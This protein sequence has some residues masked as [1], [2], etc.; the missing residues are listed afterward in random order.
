MTTEYGVLGPLVAVRDGVP[1]E[2][3][4][5]RQ[6]AVLARLL[7]AGGRALPLDT[8]VDEVWETVPDTAV[9]TAQKYVSQL[10]SVL[11]T[12]MVRT[13]GRGYAVDLDDATLDADRFERLLADGEAEAAL[14][15]WRGEPLDGLPDLP[16]VT[17]ERTRLTELRAGA[18]EL[19]LQHLLDAGRHEL[20][21]PE[22]AQ[23]F[24]RQ[25]A[26][27]R[28]CALLMLAL[29]R[30]GRQ[31]E[32]LETF[33]CHR[34]RLADELG[35]EPGADLAALEVSILHQDAG[36]DPPTRG[37]APA[38]GN[39]PRPVSSFV[40]RERDV[41]RVIAGLGGHRVVTLTGPGGVGKTRLA[42][43][44]GARVAADHPAG[45][46]FVD[47]GA[48]ADPGLI[49][50]SL[51]GA[52]G[53]ADQPDQ[54][55]EETV[56]AAL[57]HREPL[58]LLLDNCEHLADRC[59]ALA[60]R[61]ARGCPGV[62][63][64]ATSR[65]PLG[66]DGECVLPVAPL[67]DGDARRLFADRARLA[68]T[69]EAETTAAA[70]AEV[71]RAV[72]G[73][74]LAL[75]LAAGQMR[76]LGPEALTA[77]LDERLTFESSRFDAPARQRTLQDMVAWSWALLPPAT[78]RFFA[79]LGVFAATF[80]LDAAA[81]V[82]GEGSPRRHLARLVEHSLLVR[83]PA[84]DG[85]APR[86]RLLDTLRLFAL[87]K[88][89]A[90]GEVDR[91]RRAHAVHHLQRMRT[92]GAHLYGPDELRWSAAVEAEEPNLHA[93]LSWAARHD[94]RL[95][96]Q[97][98]LAAWPY[99]EQRWRERFAIA[100]LAGVVDPPGPPV[101]ARLRAWGLAA[102]AWLASNPG[103][104][105]QST[106][107]GEQAVDL[108][109]EHGDEVGL[110]TALVALGAAHGNGGALDAAQACAEE[111]QALA[112]R[113]GNRQLLA[114][115]LYTRYF[116]ASRR[117]DFAEAVRFGRAELAEWTAVGSERGQALALRHVALAV[118]HQGDLEQSADLCRAALTLFRRIGDTASV[119]HVQT[120]QADLARLRGDLDE[121]EAR[122][123]EALDELRRVGDRRCTA[124]TYKNVALV[125][126]ARGDHDRALPLF[127]D[128]VRLRLELGDTAGL[129]ECFE[130]LAAALAATGRTAEARA[131]LDAADERRRVSGAAAS[132]EDDRL[133]MQVQALVD[134][135]PAAFPPERGVDFVLAL[136]RQEDAGA[137]AITG[138]R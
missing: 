28:L 52:L 125:A 82:C 32:A 89:R 44:T 61:I 49:A 26:R 62:R 80:T 7:L 117:G 33:R 27:E 118:R 30:C 5:P 35:L 105:P 60:D 12:A 113:L 104:S 81:A 39:L 72:D 88:L 23:L 64:L 101:P 97:L 31:E 77:H 21:V 71:C 100:Y 56:L 48:I 58:L 85:G 20:V 136:D 54:D 36:L 10:R 103:E 25:P 47:L 108:F 11:G 45:V 94:R 106:R 86:Y 55:D 63:V 132:A 128:A 59:A 24:A 137:G 65:R 76:A 91:R 9:K 98:G 110:A 133:R 114:Y 17:A 78:Q 69:P 18:A 70:V 22:A 15:L 135:A 75:E 84:A 129:A 40:G 16:F 115:A 122:Y 116:I 66:I 3:G 93:A 57:R 67:P 13:V 34:A 121:A 68:G 87:E 111:G 131:L 126:S 107:W 120:T 99:W 43:E 74:P 123:T 138:S 90:A 79:R 112:E 19:R 37:P 96:L 50:H 4:G 95:A 51:V 6:R 1:L 92:A 2:L 8:L 127:R 38:T 124:S 29:Y 119:A 41:A 53:L 83:E 109:R 130:G 73:L 42:V 14:A 46:W 102:L 134:G